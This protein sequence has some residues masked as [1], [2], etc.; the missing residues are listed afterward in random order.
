MIDHSCCIRLFQGFSV[1]QRRVLPYIKRIKYIESIRGLVIPSVD[2]IRVRHCSMQQEAIR[3]VTATDVAAMIPSLTPEKYKG[4]SGKIAVVGGCQEY[5]GAP[6]F[7]AFSALKLGA[8]LSHVFCAQG[9][10]SVIKGY[11]PELIVHP[12]LMDSSDI[13]AD[14]RPVDEIKGQILDKVGAW[15]SKFGCIVVGPGLGR[16]DFI[17]ACVKDIMLECRSLGI[18][19]VIDADGL[20]IVNQDPTIVKG[21]SRIVLTP[22]VV[23][24]QRLANALGV[25]S[26]D[27]Q[28]AEHMSKILQGPIIVRKGR[29]DV[30]MGSNADMVGVCREQG[31]PRRAGGQGD[32]L[33]GSIATFIAW[34]TSAENHDTISKVLFDACGSA[35][36]IVR[37]AACR[38]FAHKGRA[39]GATDL[40][41]QLGP[42]ADDIK[43]DSSS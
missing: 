23:E 10:A 21:C 32:V 26:N 22:N 35:C 1:H 19:L 33:A 38:A 15:A 20:W 28:C 13:H 29:E 17:M 41:H 6:F 40:M 42:L 2:R 8:D 34:N 5:T 30:I 36:F 27:P 16:D 4:Q 12:Y 37:R 43:H 39:M 31:S 9:A 3:S 18:P 24:F 7:A 14:S 11:S 25:D